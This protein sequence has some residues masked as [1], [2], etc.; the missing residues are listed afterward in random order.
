MK[1]MTFQVQYDMSFSNMA[2][3]H[4]AW[5]KIKYVWHMAP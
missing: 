5:D 1:H 3:C 4:V 2:A